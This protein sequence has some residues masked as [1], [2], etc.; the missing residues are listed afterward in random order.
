[1]TY[2]VTVQVTTDV[3]TNDENEAFSMAISKVR[4]AVGDNQDGA[5]EMWVTGVAQDANGYMVYLQ[6]EDSD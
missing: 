2:R 6:G 1:M 5:D 3:E 4:E